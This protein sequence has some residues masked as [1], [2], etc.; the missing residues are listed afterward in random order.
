MFLHCGLEEGRTSLIT[1]LCGGLTWRRANWRRPERSQSLT[2]N[3]CPSDSWMSVNS[4]YFVIQVRV[5]TWLS[6]DPHLWTQLVYILLK[7]CLPCG[8]LERHCLS[9][10][11]PW[12]ISGTGQ[13]WGF[14][15]HVSTEVPDSSQI[16]SLG[17]SDFSKCGRVS[18]ECSH[19]N[20]KQAQGE[21]CYPKNGKVYLQWVSLCQTLPIIPISGHW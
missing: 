18:T 20:P 21:C 14:A 10:S 15:R 9:L 6:S 11:I 12:M 7:K 13:G 1:L 17:E 8:Y 5:L 4:L 19:G 16:W 2:L 3:Q